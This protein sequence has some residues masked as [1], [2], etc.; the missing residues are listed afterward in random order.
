[1]RPHSP[2]LSQ[3]F[4]NIGHSFSHVL[5]FLYPTV[6]LSLEVS[7]GLSYGDLII[8]MLGGQVLFGL[9]A[10][11]AGW[12]GDRWSGLG[13][14]V[15]FFLGTGGAAIVTGLARTPLEIGL[16]LALI[17]LFA[18]IYHPVGLAWLVRSAVNRGRA[19]GFNG[20]FGA[21]G[22]AAG[23][24]IAGFLTD[25]VGWR[26]A[27]I[28][29]GMAAMA[30][31]AGLAM[32]WRLGL[33]GET[34][35]AA[36]PTPTPTRDAVMR[37]FVVLS[38]T[39]TC[40]GLINQ[41][42]PVLLPKLFADRAGALAGGGAFGI[43]GLVTLVYL[44]AALAQFVGGYLADRFALKT[45]YVGVYAAL[46]PL[47]V[48]ASLLGD[49]P[50]VVAMI[51]IVF[52]NSGSLP[53]ENSLL[54]LYTP[55]KWRA[56]AYGAKFVLS[57]GVSALSVPLIATVYDATGGFFWIFVVLAGLAIIAAVAAAMLPADETRRHAMAP[58]PVPNPAE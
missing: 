50:L 48:T 26:A 23:P 21:L 37:A 39:M 42:F 2:V 1:M 54:A 15:I 35:A 9:A 27:F 18:S 52:L 44:F 17:G 3:A 6:V 31:G 8:L 29:P 56:T 20:V 38:I 28:V 11:P 16:G 51:A 40:A 22:V 24:A 57:L 4:S 34:T 13:M 41:A 46:V 7:W 43:G 36:R 14:M 25:F 49:T 53:T 12:L 45:L 5:T 30:T 10:L 32:C 33:V 55:G 58:Q 47:I 19:L